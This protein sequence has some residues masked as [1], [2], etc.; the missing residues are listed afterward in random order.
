MRAFDRDL[1]RGGHYGQRSCEPQQKAEHMAAPT[2]AA[3]VKKTLANPE[4]STHGPS[5][6]A[7]LSRPT[8]AFGHCGHGGTC[9]LAMWQGERPLRRISMIPEPYFARLTSTKSGGICC[10]LD[11]L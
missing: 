10:T 9:R 4:P 11:I 6:W 3:R 7:T 5:R 2:T 1:I 8:V